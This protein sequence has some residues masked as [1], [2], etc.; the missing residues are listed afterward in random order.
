MSIIG[1]LPIT[2]TNGTVADATQ[3]MTD[4]NFIISQINSNAAALSGGNAFLGTQTINGDTIATLLATQTIANK[5]INASTINSPAITTPAISSPTISGGATVNGTMTVN[6]GE[7]RIFGAIVPSVATDAF[8]AGSSALGSGGAWALVASAAGADL[9][10]NDCVSNSSGQIMFRLL[11]DALNSATNWLLVNRIGATVQNVQIANGT[12][13]ATGDGRVYG[14]S[15]HN[16]A[17]PVTGTTNQFIAS[18]TYTPTLTNA[19]NVAS[20][21]NAGA[22]NWMRVG[23]VV[24]VSG[25]VNITPTAGGGAGTE[26]RLSLPI[27]ATF[28]A[29]SNLGGAANGAQGGVQ[30]PGAQIGVNLAAPTIASLQFFAPSTNLHGYTYTFT[31]VV[32]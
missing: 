5:T 10:Y 13:I 14:T 8:L 12:L 23:N 3:V 18:G 31:Y 7:V 30:A 22:A 2:L 25:G 19:T 1:A 17:N 27:A 16:N 15:L 21:S 26:L 32:M 9:K 28:A 20:S 24:T 6:T 11:N 29:L 4:L